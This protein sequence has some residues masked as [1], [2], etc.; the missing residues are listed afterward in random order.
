[1][2]KIKDSIQIKEVDFLL[3]F[4]MQVVLKRNNMAQRKMK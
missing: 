4:R 3:I 2:P 1:M